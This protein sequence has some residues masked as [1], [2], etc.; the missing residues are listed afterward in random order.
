MELNER[1]REDDNKLREHEAT[2][3]EKG[4][5]GRKEK[6]PKEGERGRVKEE[7]VSVKED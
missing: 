3:R 2:A 5:R 4:R 7:G 6:G 1:Y